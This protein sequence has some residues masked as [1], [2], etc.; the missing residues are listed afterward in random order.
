M[1]VRPVEIAGEPW[2]EVYDVSVGMSDLSP[3][4]AFELS[5]N[6]RLC[7]VAC[8]ASNYQVRFRLPLTFVTAER[9]NEMMFEVLDALEWM[10]DVAGAGDDA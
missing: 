2:L 6:M 10:L 8:G 9:L 5:R 4:E 7:E 1:F 3:V